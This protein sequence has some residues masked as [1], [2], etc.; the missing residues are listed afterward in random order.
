MKKVEQA[1]KDFEA[2]RFKR[3]SKEKF[4]EHMKSW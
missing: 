3:Y 2:G 4:L 1:W